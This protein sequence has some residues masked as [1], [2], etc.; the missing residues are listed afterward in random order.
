MISY[1][2]T[3]RQVNEV[4]LCSNAFANKLPHIALYRITHYPIL[5]LQ[6]MHLHLYCYQTI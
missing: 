5:S 2:P 6:I 4:L 3:D 1:F